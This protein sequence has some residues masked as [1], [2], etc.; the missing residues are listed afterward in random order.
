MTFSFN[1]PD[2][3]RNTTSFPTTPASETAFRDSMQS[4]L[5]QLAAELNSGGSSAIGMSG[6]LR[7]G[8]INGNF[9]VNQRSKLGTVILAA[10]AYGHDRFKAGA[11]GCTYTFTTT[12]GESILTITAGSLQQVIE[13][14]SLQ[15]GNY[16][17][18][19]QGTATGRINGGAYAASGITALL[20]GGTNVTVEFGVG[21]LSR[22]QFNAGLSA[23]PFQPRS[24][25]EELAL[26]QR[27]YQTCYTTGFVPVQKLDNAA[28]EVASA[29]TTGLASTKVN[30]FT[31]M[32]IAPTT[33]VYDYNG[34]PGKV[35]TAFAANSIGTTVLANRITDA[36][37]TGISDGANPFTVGT[38][39][40]FGWTA[41]AEL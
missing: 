21:T 28:G 30:F 8:I 19:W 20:P 3:Y 15:S 7:Q 31:R 36:G 41:D 27:Y 38:K 16:T 13:G 10:G 29:E 4:L 35:S 14:T 34:S 17:L 6:I 40:W 23:M 25:A 39:Y 32:R 12:G 9:L 2:G 24:F 26:C 1:P 11:S 22:V 18:S 37:F 33:I 5:D